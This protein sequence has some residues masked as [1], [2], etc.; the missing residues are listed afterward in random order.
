MTRSFARQRRAEERSGKRAPAATGASHRP[1]VTCY[2]VPYIYA[3]RDLL[4]AT[5]T[6]PSRPPPSSSGPP[7]TLYPLQLTFSNFTPTHLV[8]ARTKQTARKSTGG[9]APRKQLAAKARKT[10][11]V[12]VFALRPTEASH[13]FIMTNPPRRPLLVV[14]RSLIASGR[15]RLPFV[16]SVATRSPRSSLSASCLSS[17]WSVR[18]PRISRYVTVALFGRLYAWC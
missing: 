1:R 6:L 12:R 14:S 7:H 2:R 11:P 3:G 17:V 5:A 15:V 16:K 18:L 13:P 8:M 10:Q 9:K 4:N